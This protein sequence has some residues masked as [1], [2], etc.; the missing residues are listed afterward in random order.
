MLSGI[1]AIMLIVSR[2]V[3]LNH[4]RIGYETKR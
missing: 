1:M 2:I 3:I 4:W